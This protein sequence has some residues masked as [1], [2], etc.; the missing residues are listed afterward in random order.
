MNGTKIDCTYDDPVSFIDGV[1][2]EVL[3]YKYFLLNDTTE[4]KATGHIWD[5]QLY[6]TLCNGDKY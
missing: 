4:M 1:R 6:D 5:S 2:Y 3:N